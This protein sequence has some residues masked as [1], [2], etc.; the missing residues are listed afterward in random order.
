MQTVALAAQ[1]SYGEALADYLRTH[2]EDALYR[3]SLLSASFIEA[4]LGPDEIVALHYELLRTELRSHPARER[5]RLSGEA[6]QFL[7]EAVIAYGVKF[8]EYLDLRLSQERQAAAARTALERADQ[9]AEAAVQQ[10]NTFLGSLAHEVRTSM[11]AIHGFARLMRR[12]ESYDGRAIEAILN[13]AARLDEL[14]ASL[15]EAAEMRDPR[16]ESHRADGRVA[17]SSE[18]HGSPDLEGADR[19]RSCAH[20]IER[21][22]L[23]VEDDAWIRALVADL[24]RDEG[25]SVRGA[26]NGE[27]ALEILDDWLPE[28]ILLDLN[29]PIL[30]GWEF[31][32]RQLA[33]QRWADVPVVILTA[34]QE[35]TRDVDELR[36]AAIVPK[37]FDLDA[38]VATVTSL[39]PGEARP[40]TNGGTR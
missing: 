7:L 40:H 15:L 39:A 12:R 6:H 34:A 8:G 22:V 5:A 1:T 31:R 27:T 32:S 4:G 29:M 16:Q 9:R 18:T 26:E 3:V 35:L 10:R 2:S 20:G 30:D 17:T 11:T 38:L 37:P 21:R 13:Q 36:A 33:E 25:F 19:N 24:L 14:L 23:I 28:V